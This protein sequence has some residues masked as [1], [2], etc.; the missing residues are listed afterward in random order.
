MNSRNFKRVSFIIFFAFGFV[1]FNSQILSKEVRTDFCKNAK[2]NYFYGTDSFYGLMNITLKRIGITDPYKMNQAVNNICNNEKLQNSFFES[3]HQI[4]RG[5]DKQQYLSIGMNPTNAQ[6]LSDYFNH[7]NNNS[8]TTTSPT[9][10]STSSRDIVKI[11]IKDTLIL[12]KK[13]LLTALFKNATLINDSTVIRKEFVTYTDFSDG[14]I[15]YKTSIVKEYYYVDEEKEE[16]KINVVLIS[17]SQ[18]GRMK[19][20]IIPVD[21]YKDSYR[22]RRNKIIYLKPEKRKNFGFKTVRKDDET[23]FVTTYLDEENKLEEN[24]YDPITF[25]IKF[26]TITDVNIQNSFKNSETMG[27]PIFTYN[28]L[29]DKSYYENGDVFSDVFKKYYFLYGEIKKVINNDGDSDYKIHITKTS[30]EFDNLHS[31][32]GSFVNKDII[33]NVEPVDLYDK[34]GN[35]KDGW[36]GRYDLSFKDYKKLKDLLVEGRKIK[37]SYIEGGGGS[38]GTATEGMFFFNYIEKID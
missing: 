31:D 27:F 28:T 23:Y 12:D 26:N 15:E 3:I 16:K 35:I 4:S 29:M 30:K 2:Y 33:V 5:L 21:I 10:S 8:T 38:L 11:D 24:Y 19:M 17:N 13:E 1:F 14:E 18:D 6:I 7:R 36:E 37:F 25:E 9:V 34:N 22:T 20:D 32:M